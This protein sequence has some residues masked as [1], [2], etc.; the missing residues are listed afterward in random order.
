M[1]K[2]LVDRLALRVA[3]RQGWAKYVIAAVIF[4]FE[5]NRKSA[6]SVAGLLIG[7]CDPLSQLLTADC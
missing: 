7:H 3:S 6:G 5:D 2:A 4:F 1:L